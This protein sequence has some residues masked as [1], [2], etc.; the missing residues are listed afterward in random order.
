MFKD[1]F[2]D[3]EILFNVDKATM[4]R[5][6]LDSSVPDMLASS[7]VLSSTDLLICSFLLSNN[8]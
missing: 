1:F 6:S 7:I 8:S 4:R 2:E 3:N 5:K